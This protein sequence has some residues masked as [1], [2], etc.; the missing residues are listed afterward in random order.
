MLKKVRALCGADPHHESLEVAKAFKVP[1]VDGIWKQS[2]KQKIYYIIF[3]VIL[4]W[5]SWLP[6]ALRSIRTAHAVPNSNDGG[7]DTMRVLLSKSHISSPDALCDLC[8]WRKFQALTDTPYLFS[9]TLN[10]A[11]LSSDLDNSL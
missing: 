10:V 2:Q 9:D 7:G 1:M 3:L 4:S 6:A 5:F 8:A 11:F